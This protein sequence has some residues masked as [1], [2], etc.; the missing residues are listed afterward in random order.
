ISTATSCIRVRRSSDNAEQDIGFSGDDL[1]TTALASFV[2]SD[3]AYVVKVYDQTGNGEHLEAAS[4]GQQPRIVDAGSYDGK[5]VFNG[6][7]HAMRIAGLV[8]GTPQ[9]A[10]YW[11][12]AL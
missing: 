6:S 3:S 2:G 10:L 9:T 5:L 4:S 8:L 7:S 1:N 11:R 12:M